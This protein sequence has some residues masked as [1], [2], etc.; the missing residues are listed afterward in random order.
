MQSLWKKSGSAPRMVKVQLPFGP[1]IPPPGINPGKMKTHVHT[2]VLYPCVHSSSIHKI[3][4]VETTQMV[5][6]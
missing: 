4:N 2:Q 1:A 3:Q 5:I 6:K